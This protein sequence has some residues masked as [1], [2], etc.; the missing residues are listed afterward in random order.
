MPGARPNGP[1]TEEKVYKNGKITLQ[2]CS[3]TNAVERRVQRRCLQGIKSQRVGMILTRQSPSSTLAH[4]LQSLKTWLVGA[5]IIR[6]KV[7]AN[8]AT[9]SSG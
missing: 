2:G 4:T 1:I 8:D 5:Y 7:D 6:S 3:K 9:M